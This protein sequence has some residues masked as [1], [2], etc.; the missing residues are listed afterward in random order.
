MGE[1][2]TAGTSGI[3]DDNGLTGA[4]FSYQWNRQ[5]L[6]TALD[7]DIPGAT[8]STRTVAAGDEGHVLRVTVKFTDDAGYEESLTSLGVEV[9]Q[10]QNAA[11]KGS[12]GSN[13][14]CHGRTHHQRGGPGG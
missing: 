10:A 8:A 7:E 5:S 4:T 11:P 6:S 14:P 3:A 2:L 12:G 13:S 1:T 9:S